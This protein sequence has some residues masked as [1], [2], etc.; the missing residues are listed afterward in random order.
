MKILF[1][2]YSSLC[3]HGLPQVALVIK[4]LPVNA[5]DVRGVV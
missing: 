5:G 1:T 4:T 2:K 3:K